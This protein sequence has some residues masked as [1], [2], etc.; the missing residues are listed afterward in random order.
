M[1][2][3]AVRAFEIG[4]DGAM[5]NWQR[6]VDVIATI[7]YTARGVVYSTVG[8]IAIWAAVTGFEPEGVEGALRE[9]ADM[10]FGGVALLLLFIGLSAFCLWRVT[11]AVV[12]VDGDGRSVKGLAV[13]T[14]L[15]LS[16]ACYGFVAIS[17]ADLAWGAP[18]ED[19]STFVRVV[20]AVFFQPFGRVLLVLAATVILTMGAAHIVGA[21]QRRFSDQLDLPDAGHMTLVRVAQT[22]LIVR[23]LL[24]CAMGCFLAYAALTFDPGKAKGMEAVLNALQAQAFGGW[25]LLIAGSGLVSYAAYAFIHAAFS[26][27]IAER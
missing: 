7:G 19:G 23:G 3:L 10:P 8:G 4:T 27:R 1:C 24:F 18:E 12:D 9:I 25:I 16:A 13:R 2:A 22:G 5:Q 11:Q 15:I 26:R 6:V 20:V 21:L 14:G 17:A